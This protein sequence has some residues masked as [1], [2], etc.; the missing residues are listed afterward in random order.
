MHQ[1]SA[2][3]MIPKPAILVATTVDPCG[4]ADVVLV[5]TLVGELRCI[6]K[7]EDRRF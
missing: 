7:H 4:E 2:H 5:Q 1:Y 6:L 3:R